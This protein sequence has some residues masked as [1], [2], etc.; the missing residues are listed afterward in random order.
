LRNDLYIYELC[1]YFGDDLLA[2]KSIEIIALPV[3]ELER[4]NQHKSMDTASFIASVV[5]T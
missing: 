3:R 5:Y 4:Q 1:W 2:L